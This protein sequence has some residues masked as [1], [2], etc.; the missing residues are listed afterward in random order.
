MVRAALKPHYYNNTVTKDEFVD[1]NKRI[2]RHLYE[3]VGSVD[4]L[5]SESKAKW[6]KI[7][8]GEVNNA[9][10]RLKDTKASEAGESSGAASS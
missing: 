2:S 6:E 8:N 7:A 1:I 3:L 5:D 9:I 10:A 4:G